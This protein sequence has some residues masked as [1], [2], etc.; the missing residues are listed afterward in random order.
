MTNTASGIFK[1]FLMAGF[2]G[3]CHR[4][5]NANGE[6]DVRL[7]MI[8]ATQ[9][10][11]HVKED[12]KNL[13]ELGIETA[14]DGVRWH[15]IEKEKGKYDFSSLTPMVD[16]ARENGIQV[17]W[18]LCHYGWPDDVDVFDE[19]F[20]D[21]FAAFCAATAREIKIRTDNVPF[22]TLINEMSFLAHCA[23]QTG[24]F[25]PYAQGRGDDLKRQLVKA[26]IAGADAIWAVD[27]RARFVHV[28][29]LIHVIAPRDRPEL[30]EEAAQVRETQFA[31]WDMLA[32]LR[33][34]E[35]G[36]HPR[37]LDIMGMNF[38]AGNQWEHMGER[39]HWH[40]KPRDERWKPL[41]ALI[42]EVY[43][44]YKRPIMLG[45]TSHVGSGR[46][47]WMREIAD[48]VK[49]LQDKGVPFE[50]ICL[51]PII[52]RMDWDDP[53]HWHNSGLFDYEHEPDGNFRRMLN[54]DY[55]AEVRR[56]QKMLE[57]PQSPK[58]KPPSPG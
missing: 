48:E 12:Y 30:T 37:Y 18:T 49:K 55:A 8:A 44:R 41:H 58:A 17:I 28:D 15:L 54:E 26:A 11:I 13:R 31:V 43:N 20:V 47:E 2:E 39:L 14:R 25:S 45:E 3:A 52:D 16:A 34:P 1:S 19:S 9:H 7:D 4:R 57:K 22:Y 27:P 24:G 56:A 42:E 6:G 36:G 29:P 46:A 53:N 32:G 33:H 21:R 40:V 35:L 10:D 23:G 50:G 51:Y 5:K 38:Y